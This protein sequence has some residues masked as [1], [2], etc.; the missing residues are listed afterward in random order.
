VL[1][2]S[3]GRAR[4]PG[5]GLS[6]TAASPPRWLGQLTVAREA[7]GGNLLAFEFGFKYGD[8]R[9]TLPIDACCGRA[10]RMACHQLRRLGAKTKRV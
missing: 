10:G 1:P 7:F 2:G 8:P 6:A 3:E 5:A 9:W 4:L